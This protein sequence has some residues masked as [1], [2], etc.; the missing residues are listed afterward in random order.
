MKV[1][2][3][4]FIIALGNAKMT[5][6]QLSTETGLAVATISKIKNGQRS[7]RPDSLGKIAEALKVRVED[8]VD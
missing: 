5:V 4:K 1:D 7:A 6:H 8:L 2:T 3:R